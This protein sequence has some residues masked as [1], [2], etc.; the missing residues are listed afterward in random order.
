MTLASEQYCLQL[1]WVHYCSSDFEPKL[2]RT[3]KR[4]LERKSFPWKRP[5][6]TGHFGASFEFEKLRQNPRDWRDSDPNSGKVCRLPRVPVQ[7]SGTSWVCVPD[8]GGYYSS[9][10]SS[11]QPVLGNTCNYIVLPGEWVEAKITL[12]WIFQQQWEINGPFPYFFLKIINH[13]IRPSQG[14]R[15][16]P[17]WFDAAKLW[18]LRLII[19]Q[20]R[21]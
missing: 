7:T 18:E 19:L 2:L 21:A 11:V 10:P 12:L 8:N 16:V 1:A 4:H 20:L 3:W 15:N 6:K 9:F 17:Y 14:V 5:R 13:R